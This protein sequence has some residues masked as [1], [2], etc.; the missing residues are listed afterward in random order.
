MS[1]LSNVDPNKWLMIPV[2]EFEYLR[3]QIRL[4]SE[5]LESHCDVRV[6]DIVS[7]L[8]PVWRCESELSDLREQVR[9]MGEFEVTI[10]QGTQDVPVDEQIEI[11]K[12]W[13]ADGGR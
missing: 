6:T 1:N 7:G 8:E 12:R 13:I 3:R 4:L 9:A 5:A 2:S 11:V 10:L